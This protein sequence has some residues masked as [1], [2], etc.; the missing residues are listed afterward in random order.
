M[1]VSG[2]IQCTHFHLFEYFTYA[3]LS[4]LM[5]PNRSW[6]SDR[7]EVK[8]LHITPEEV[9]INVFYVS[10]WNVLEKL[11]WALSQTFFEVEIERSHSAGTG[12][13]WKKL[14]KIEEVL[15]IKVKVTQCKYFLPFFQKSNVAK[16]KFELACWRKTT[17]YCAVHIVFKDTPSF[18]SE[19]RH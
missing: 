8:W 18:L 19:L 16:K 17:M 5:S 14:F 4:I 6:H 13:G 10:D 2:W 9:E 12:N 3:L 7:L 1:S 11:L 15:K